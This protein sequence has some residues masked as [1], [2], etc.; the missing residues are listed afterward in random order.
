M[1]CTFSRIMQ[2]KQKEKE[3]RILILGLDNAGKTTIVKRLVGEPIDAIEPTLGFQ[4]RTLA[5]RPPY[6]IHLWDVGGQT[7]IRAYWRNYFERTDGLIWV[8]DAADIYRLQLCKTELN[9]IL[10]QERLTG[11]SVLIWAN[12]Q[13]VPGALTDGE[14]A[15]ILEL[16]SSIH[17]QNRHWQIRSCSAVTGDG[18]ENGLNW[19]V[20]DIASRIF[21][22][23]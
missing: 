6:Q 17:F 14:I 20:T 12:K 3:I 7:S 11:A 21:L 22:L 1:F 18:L 5:N 16:E 15:K 13:D 8:V 23:A 19:I 10:Q 4:I 2:I 9:R